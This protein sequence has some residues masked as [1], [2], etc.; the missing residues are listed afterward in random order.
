VRCVT[1]YYLD[2]ND[3]DSDEA[4]AEDPDLTLVPEDSERSLEIPDTQELEGCMLFHTTYE[5]MNN[6]QESLVLNRLFIITRIFKVGINHCY[7]K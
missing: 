4:Q 2:H 7:K 1:H 6:P 3:E 5:L